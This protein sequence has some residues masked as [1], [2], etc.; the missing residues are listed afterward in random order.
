MKL[1]R[2]EVDNRITTHA[3]SLGNFWLF[4]LIR[5][6]FRQ[7]YGL[8][9]TYLLFIDSMI[10]LPL[11]SWRDGVLLSGFV[12]GDRHS[13]SGGYV[14][15]LLLYFSVYKH[16]VSQSQGREARQISGSR[17]RCSAIL[18]LLWPR[19]RYFLPRGCDCCILDLAL[20][21]LVELEIR[22]FLGLLP[23]KRLPCGLGTSM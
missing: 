12:C 13:K 15:N 1:L 6:N 17:A 9:S 21:A 14:Q 3:I 7:A 8:G 10:R 19:I 2:L 11:T 22:F 5:Y 20:I 4:Y 18:A 23:F 16:G